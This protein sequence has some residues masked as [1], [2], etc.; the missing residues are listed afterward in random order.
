MK[1]LARQF[2][3]HW[4]KRRFGDR[5]IPVLLALSGGIDSMVLAHLLLAAKI[6]FAAAHCNFSLRGADSDGDAA[7]VHDWCRGRNVECHI[8][9]F[10]TAG[11]AAEWGESIQVA[12]RNLRYGW[13]EQLRTQYGYAAVLTAH[14]AGDV[15]ETMLINLCRGTGIAGLHGIPERNGAVI[16]PLL[17]ATRAGIAAYAEKHGITWREDASNAKTE[18][19]RNALRHEVLPKLET[20]MPGAAARIAETA[21]RLGDAEIFYRA[22]IAKR[23]G[24]L[25]ER[26]GQDWY[27]PLKLLEKTPGPA[28][29]AWELFTPFGF[30]AEQIPL[31]LG[32]AGSESG[33]AIASPAHRVIRHRDF[34]VVTA[35]APASA[36]LVLVEEIPGAVNTEGG[37]FSFSWEL[38]MAALP[39]DPN[40]ACLH[41]DEI[42]LPLVLR[43]RREGDYFYPL[44]M[45]GKKK[46]LKRFLIDIKLPLPEK[47]RIRILECDK[48]I[49]WIAGK[50][51]DERFKVRPATKRVLKVVFQPS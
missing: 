14:H 45:G 24:R 33:R 23:L 9:V 31:I 35:I 3:E 22:A 19:L 26:R 13:F 38:P 48:K 40:V 8:Q 29:V 25:L 39:D 43:T 2:T 27:I 30:S 49:L 4:A 20:L 7:F 12:A 50:R 18:Y 17:F 41:G 5:K 21:A 10:N 34:L 47:D 42:A 1:D 28:T 32:L 44:G 37:S 16:R 11:Y 51:I 15:A 36:D 46:K 6:P